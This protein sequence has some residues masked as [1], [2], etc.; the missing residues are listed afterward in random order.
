[1]QV[2]VLVVLDLGKY[3][4]ILL[5]P[6]VGRVCDLGSCSLSRNDAGEGDRAES[7]NLNK[8]RAKKK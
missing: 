3:P 5:Q 4:D 8:I 6:D 7:N 2:Q 1:M